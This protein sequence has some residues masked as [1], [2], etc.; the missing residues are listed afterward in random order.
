M[1]SGLLVGMNTLEKY[2]IDVLNSRKAVRI[3]RLEV[4]LMNRSMTMDEYRI[5]KKRH[6]TQKARERLHGWLVLGLVVSV[7]EAVFFQGREATLTRRMRRGEIL[8]KDDFFYI[9]ERIDEKEKRQWEDHVTE[10]QWQMARWEAYSLNE[11]VD[12]VLREGFGRRIVTSTLMRWKDEPDEATMARL[13]KWLR[14]WWMGKKDIDSIR[15]LGRAKQKSNRGNL[16]WLWQDLTW[17]WRDQTS[18][19]ER[20]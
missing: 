4:P 14:A 12:V 17:R 11:D 2:G 6:L 13:E 7:V 1:H 8:G 5:V 3:G 9:L 16:K 20:Q 15:E 10:E 18:D 19:A